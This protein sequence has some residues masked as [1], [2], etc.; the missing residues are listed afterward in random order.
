[1]KRLLPLSRYTVLDLTLAR[2]GPTAV[3]LLSDWGANVIRVEPPINTGTSSSGLTKDRKTPDSQNLHRNKRSITINLKTQKGKALF[4]SLASQADVIVENFRAEV[5]HRLGI[6]YD[7]VK[8]VNQAVIYASI[9]GFGQTGPYSNRPGVDQ[10]VQGTSGLMSITGE[11]GKG[12]M[13][14]GIAI[15]DTSAGMFLG[16]GILL[17]LIHREQTGEGQ[18]VHTSLLESMLCKIDFQGAR[19]TM[20]GEIPAQEGNNHPT[21]A[22]MGVFEV[23]DGQVNL[24]ASSPKM[25]KSFCQV[26]NLPELLEDERFS[27]FENR[28]LNRDQLW[29]L[30][31]NVTRNFSTSELVEKLN[32]V[33]C[34]CGPI[35][36]IGEAFEDIQARHL[37]MQKSVSH[38]TL[39]TLNLVRSPINLTAFQ[40]LDEFD[41]PGPELGEHTEEILLE[42]GFK[43]KEINSLRDEH[44]I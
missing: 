3:R 10:V 26:M 38:K 1:M 7:S 19:Y 17:A 23:T 44:A 37:K 32:A 41:R 34:P 14:A 21:N 35:Y 13:R 25:F 11:P 9:S 2:A 6:D 24:A 30:V 27:T 15:S 43:Q 8:R 5:K 18:W 33:G 16:Q 42:M 40:D 22:P 12:P 36:N 28:F 20:N 39:G 31:N 29:E 4:M